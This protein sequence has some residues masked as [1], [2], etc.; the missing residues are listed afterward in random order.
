[1]LETIKG[2]SGG[3]LF[4]L[5]PSFNNYVLFYNKDLFEQYG[6]PFPKNKM[7]WDEVLDLT[8]RFPSE[9]Q[10]DNRIYGFAFGANTST[11]SVLNEIAGTLG[12]G[13]ADSDLTKI[14]FQTNGWKQAVEL[15]V[16]AMNSKA[17]YK[18]SDSAPGGLSG[19]VNDFLTSHLFVSKR[20]AMTIDSYFLISKLQLSQS[21]LKDS[22]LTNWDVVTVPVDPQ[23]PD[24]SSKVTVSQIISIH[25]KTA[26]T[27]A[28]WEF[29]K[30]I[31][32]DE[33]AKLKSRS[34]NELLSRSNYMTERD[35]H[36]L[37]SFYM[38]RSAEN[39]FR[40]DLNRLPA[41][42]YSLFNAALEQEINEV[43]AKQKS[44][45]DALK[46]I[47]ARSQEALVKSKAVPPAK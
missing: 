20:A 47:E 39:K 33:F 8:E 42:F 9:D 13:F 37:Q 23:N 2:K 36:S 6:V 29:V 45:D 40:T 25:A 21:V 14:T 16:R 4:G 32:G 38:L 19:N 44:R 26:N 31:N 12:L 18:S 28:A 41:D 34:T 35:G 5:T 43:L 30:F 27:R 3:A 46:S 24:L 15:L 11:I 7:T 22:A 17:F 10:G 1:M